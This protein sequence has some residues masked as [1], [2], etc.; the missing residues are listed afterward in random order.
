MIY[1]CIEHYNSNIYLTNMDI[2]ACEREKEKE[3]NTNELE[4]CFI[5]LDVHT[6]S[7]ALFQLHELCFE[8]Y[9]ICSC[10][11]YV[12][13]NCLHSWFNTSVN[14]CPICRNNMKKKTPI[15]LILYEKSKHFI[16]ICTH[17]VY[18]SYFYVLQNLYITTY[19]MGYLFFYFVGLIHVFK[20]CV[21][22]YILCFSVM[23]KQEQ[24]E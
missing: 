8:Y 5:C 3:K 22:F 18:L 11:G 19:N 21:I 2:S 10:S 4:D 15:Y 9:K 13:R 16:L 14:K 1:R 24:N 7:R 23:D 17:N 6:D 20:L 12:H